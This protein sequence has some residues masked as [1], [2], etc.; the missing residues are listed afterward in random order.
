MLLTS[1]EY[2]YRFYC[3]CVR[4]PIFLCGSACVQCVCV[5]ECVCVCVCVCGG[6]TGGNRP[7]RTL[8]LRRT[9]RMRDQIVHSATEDYPFMFSARFGLL[10][11]ASLTHRRYLWRHRRKDWLH[12]WHRKAVGGWNWK[13]YLRINNRC[14]LA[15]GFFGPPAWICTPGSR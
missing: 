9:P 7:K 5:S 13:S 11:R 1:T 2:H 10:L 4:V 8:L 6:V 14:L 12:L 15:S 3:A